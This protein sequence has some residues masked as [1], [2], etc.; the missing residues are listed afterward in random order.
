MTPSA[1]LFLLP[2]GCFGGQET[3]WL[4]QVPFT[5]EPECDTQITHNFRD[6]Y[7][8]DTPPGVWTDTELS[9]QSDMLVFAQVSE[10]D[11]DTAVLVIAGE[12]WP[13]TSTGKGEWEFSW[14]G[15]EDNRLSHEHDAGYR[16]TEQAYFET[17]ET[18]TLAID[19]DVASGDW[20]VVSVDDQT[21]T[22]SDEWDNEVGMSVGDIPSNLYLAYDDGDAEGIPQSNYQDDV[23]C[24]DASCQ[25]RVIDTCSDKKKFD[26]TKTG[27][28]YEDAY[29]QLEAST[30]PYG[31]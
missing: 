24:T 7:I 15:V 22:E 30:Q 8:P 23:D 29:D 27:F 1:L 19:G 4:L 21:W 6:A 26:A 9:E 10:L 31:A 17:N 5:T 3:I 14:T 2:L 20:E 25:L 12:V 16:Y 11:A 13:G 28:D 18:I